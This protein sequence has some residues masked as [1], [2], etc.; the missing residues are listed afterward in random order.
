[1]GKQQASAHPWQDWV[2]LGFGTFW[3][4]RFTISY[5]GWGGQVYNLGVLLDSQLLLKEQVAALARRD[6]CTVV[7]YAPV[8]PFPRNCTTRFCSPTLMSWIPP[9]WT[10]AT[11]CTG[12]CLWSYNW[13][14]GRSSGN[15]AHSMSSMLYFLSMSTIGYR[16]LLGAIQD[17]SN[18]DLMQC[19]MG[20]CVWEVALPIYIYLSHQIQQE[21]YIMNVV[22]WNLE[23]I[24]FWHGTSPLKHH[25]PGAW[26]ESTL[27]AFR[28]GLKNWLCHCACGSTIVV[29]PDNG[30]IKWIYDLYSPADYDTVLL[31]CLRI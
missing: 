13:S 30:C 6:L 25:S 21:R 1:M 23:E 10:T 29:S 24:L 22:W 4:Q 16:V 31:N 11:S 28:K 18:D 3:F 2:P 14:K 5:S 27:L 7:C 20:K 12:S 9:E 8:A 17:A 15:Y 19:G 26:I